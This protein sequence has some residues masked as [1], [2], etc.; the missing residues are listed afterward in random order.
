MPE[1]ISGESITVRPVTPETYERDIARGA[2]VLPRMLQFFAQEEVESGE[3]SYFVAETKAGEHRGQ[4]GISWGGAQ[5][6]SLLRPGVGDAAEVIL[7][8]TQPGYERRG[9]GGLV[10]RSVEAAALEKGRSGLYMRVNPFNEQGATFA[11]DQGFAAV[12][13][14][15]TP[16]SAE[17][18]LQPDGRYEPSPRVAP[19]TVMHK[20]LRAPDTN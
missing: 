5:V 14:L 15:S 10:M 3:T 6:G 1:L 7:M 19:L 11:N 8:H 9:I 2:L 4:A 12:K 20:L 18:V 13:T 16:P 17:F